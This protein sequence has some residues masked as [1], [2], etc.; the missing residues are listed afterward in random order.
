MDITRPATAQAGAAN[1]VNDAAH[2]SGQGTY[3]SANGP[4]INTFSW[5]DLPAVGDFATQNNS[6]SGLSDG[7]DRFDDSSADGFGGF[8]QNLMITPQYSWDTMSPQGIIF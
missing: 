7:F 4:S 6:I 2:H 5:L 8:E 1:G 3:E